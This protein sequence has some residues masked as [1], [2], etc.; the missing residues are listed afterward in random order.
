MLAVCAGRHGRCRRA[1]RSD[2][3]ESVKGEKEMLPAGLL[4]DTGITGMG[5]RKGHTP[6]WILDNQGVLCSLCAI[7][8]TVSLPR[9]PIGTTYTPSCLR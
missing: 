7:L 3:S 5:P 1:C 6:E 9:Q 8:R 2:M 4:T